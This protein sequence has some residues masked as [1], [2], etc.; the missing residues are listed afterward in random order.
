MCVRGL[1]LCFSATI[2]QND[3]GMKTKSRFLRAPVEPFIVEPDATANDLLARMERISF[4]GRNLATARRIWEKML[5]GDCTIFLGMAGA[6]SAGGMRLIV[7][8]LL[9]QR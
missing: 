8:H 6:L 4:Q 7:A 2:C 1:H 5:A 3:R 9:S